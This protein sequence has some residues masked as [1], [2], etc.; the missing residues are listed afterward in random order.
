MVSTY[1]TGCSPGRHDAAEWGEIAEALRAEYPEQVAFLTSLKGSSSCSAWGDQYLSTT[2]NSV[3]LLSDSNSV[4]HYG[5]FNDNPQYVIIDKSMVVRER[6]GSDELD[7]ASIRSSIATYLAEADP[8]PPNVDCVGSWS[9]CSADCADKVYTVERAQSGSGAPCAAVAGATQACAA[10]EGDCPP[11]VDCAGAWSDC[12]EM[13]EIASVRT[14]TETAAASGEGTTCPPPADCAPG[15]GGC[16]ECVVDVCGV[17]GGTGHSCPQRATT[18]VIQGA[19]S[20]SGFVYA[21]KT[22]Q[23]PLGNVELR[24]KVSVQV[25]GLDGDPANLRADTDCAACGIRRLQIRTAAA[26]IAGTK[27]A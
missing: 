22:Q 18:T 2:P 12:T 3:S 25:S 8:A 7:V 9:T 5:L 20:L 11:N 27:D 15:E 19:V 10:G 16:L 4:L 6:F 24:Q 23:I 21:M 13:C 1:Y 17:C 14:W 26:S